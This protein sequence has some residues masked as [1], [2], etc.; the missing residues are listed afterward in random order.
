MCYCSSKRRPYLRDFTSLKHKICEIAD[1]FLWLVSFSVFFLSLSFFWHNGVQNF[2]Y[3]TY[4]ISL[5]VSSHFQN[6]EIK[7]F[8]RLWIFAS[9]HDL[10]KSFN[11]LITKLR[12]AVIQHLLKA[13]N[14]SLLIIFVV[15]VGILID[16]ELKKTRDQYEC[17]PKG[18][19]WVCVNAKETS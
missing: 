1:L 11:I 2:R 10:I 9:V 5:S 15:I 17:G 8:F 7:K 16:Q 18:P 14:S 12:L 19:W 3:C 13:W 4:G 6:N